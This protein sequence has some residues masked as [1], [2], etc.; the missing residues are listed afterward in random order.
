[1]IKNFV[2]YGAVVLVGICFLWI[3]YCLWQV[4]NYNQNHSKINTGDST[5][6][7]LKLLGQ[8]K[9]IKGCSENIAWGSELS[10]KKNNGECVKEYWYYSPIPILAPEMWTVGFDQQNKAI[11]KYRYA[12]P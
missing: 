2:K 9:E 7:V 11:S 10:I 12:S 4:N 1:M 6:A 5:D 8:P 3:G